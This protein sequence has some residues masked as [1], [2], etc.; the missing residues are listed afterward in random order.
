MARSKQGTGRFGEDEAAAHLEELGYRIRERRY[1]AYFEGGCVGEID[2]VAEEGE[3]LVFAEVKARSG[4]GWGLPREAVGPAKRRK[5][6]RA[7][8][9]YTAAHGAENPWRF[10]VVEVILLPGGAT[11]VRVLRGAFEADERDLR[12]L[13]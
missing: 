12:G 10:D 9:I 13:Q 3:C 1:R 8:A 2:L 11:E 4:L 6:T 7:A 5:M